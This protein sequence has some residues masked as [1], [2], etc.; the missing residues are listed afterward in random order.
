MRHRYTESGC[1]SDTSHILPFEIQLPFFFRHWT[2]CLQTHVEY[3][4]SSHFDLM[5][6]ILEQEQCIMCL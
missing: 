4:L 2:P 6:A 1:H 3:V 5:F